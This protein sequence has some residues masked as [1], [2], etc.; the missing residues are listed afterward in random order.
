MDDR[1]LAQSPTNGAARCGGVL[2][3][4][5]P[6]ACQQCLVVDVALKQ[7]VEYQLALYFVDLDH[8]GRRQ[9]VELFDL[10]SRKLI[11]PTRVYANFTGG[12]YAVY[13]CRQSVRIRVNHIRGDNAVLSGL[14]FDSQRTP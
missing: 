10:D 14:F 13:N 6:V 4:G 5:N 2:Y 1:A 8:K 7:P 12:I 3:C 11:A 9:S